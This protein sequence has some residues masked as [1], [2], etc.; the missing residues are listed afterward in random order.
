MKKMN[1]SFMDLIHKIWNEIGKNKKYIVLSFLFSLIAVIGQLYIPILFGRAI[2]NMISMGKVSLQIVFSFL[3]KACICTLI[4]SLFLYAVTLV[5]NKIAYGTVQTIRQKAIYKIQTLPLKYLDNQKTGDIVARI[6]TDTDQLS[7][8]LLLG[9]SQFFSGVITIIVTLIFMVMTSW[10]VS[11]AVILLTPLSFVVAKYISSHTYKMFRKQTDVRGLQT[12][13][14]DEKIGNLDL[15]KVFGNTNRASREFYKIN[16]ELREFSEKS[17]FYSSLTNPSTRCIN[18]IIYAVVVLFGSW[19]IISGGLTVGGLS[20]LLNYANQYMKPFNDITSV[21]TELQNAV[22]CAARIFSFLEEDDEEDCAL[23]NCAE[24]DMPLCHGNIRFEHVDFCYDEF[25]P[26]IE[27]F[28]LKIEQGK[29]IALVGPTGCGKTTLINLLMRFYDIQGGKIYLDDTD[30]YSVSR[31]S[32]RANF[33]MVLQDTWIRNATVRENIVFGRTGITDDKIIEASKKTHSWEFIRRLPKG[34]DTVLDDTTLSEGEKQL[35]CITRVMIAPPPILILDEATSSI[36]TRT[37]ILV[38]EAFDQLME[39]RT[40]FVV[41]HRL[42][43]IRSADCILVM[44][45]GRIIEQGTHE[46][47]IAKKGFYSDLYN[48]QFAGLE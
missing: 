15:I 30:I 2:D 41:A 26:L 36:D 48:C 46:E 38:Q 35:L 19:I 34:L 16:E 14:V 28:N 12:A 3:I 10:K 32:L 25:K 22:A 27:N 40:S 18:A 4:A 21:F 42:S 29:H 37:E 23:R 5:N 45:D 31:F 33:G 17:V 20:I 7:E 13:F 1:P 9:F 24:L 6:T 11:L 44:R 47:L 39:G 43:T 8:S